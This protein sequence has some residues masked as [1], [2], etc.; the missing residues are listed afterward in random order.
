MK[1]FEIY[2]RNK[3]EFLAYILF[4]LLLIVI[5]GVILFP[6]QFYD[7]WIWNYYWGPVVADAQGGTA[8]HNSVVASEGYTVV[9]ELTYGLI[10]IVALFYIYILLKKKK[11]IVDW[12]FALALMPYIVY[13]P[14][15]RVLE[16]TS[17]FQEP[18]LYWFIS[19]LI[20]V[21]IA[22]FAI[23]FLLIGL[24]LE[25]KFGSEKITMNKTLFYGGLLFLLPSLILISSWILGNQWSESTG[26]RFDVFIIVIS[27]VLFVV[28]LVYYSSDYLKKKF[29][30]AKNFGVY[31][32]ALNLVILSGHMIDGLS[33][34]ISI[35]DPFA[36]GLHYSEKHPASDMLLNIW[37]PLFPIVKFLL[38]I[39]VI[40]VFDILYKEELK[41]HMTLVNLLKIGILILGFSP[42]VRDLL[43]V[44]MGV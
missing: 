13:G 39:M 41:D 24:Y 34:Y 25:E 40:Y 23:L 11:V 6:T 21:Q 3:A 43:R 16:D 37:G 5:M 28:F 31:K 30:F 33:S 10:L 26:V 36:M 19:P 27:I 14:V 32:N 17:Y 9:S 4:S 1:I 38:I 44:T 2:S 35:K 20:Y 8:V 15:S 18:L 22:F 7:N 42:G 29:S 12:K